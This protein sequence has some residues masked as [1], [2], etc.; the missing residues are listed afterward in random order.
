MPS[1]APDV[2]AAPSWQ[3]DIRAARLPLKALL[4]RL[5]LDAAMLPYGVIADPAFAMMV[6]PHTLSLIRPGDA[7][8]PL[9][10]QVLARAD[11]QVPGKRITSR[12]PLAEA[13]FTAGQGI[14][15]KYGSRALLLVSGACAI[16]CR[17]C[18]RRHYDYGASIIP[19]SGLDAALA[20][21]AADPAITEV[22]LSGGDPL[23]LSDTRLSAVLAALAAM[24]Q[25]RIIRIHT[26]TLTVVP[27][28]VTPALLA[29]L[30]GLGKPVVIVTHT[31]HA[32]ELDAVVQ[33]A[34][35]SVR[36]AGVQ[37]LNQAVLLAGINDDTGVL[38]AHGRRLLECG[39]LPYY[40]HMP[41]PVEGASHFDVPLARAREIESELRA[42]L[43]G[44]LVPRFVAEIPGA[45]S[46][47]PLWAL[48]DT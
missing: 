46:K 42:D 16:H 24:R 48:P 18:F 38:A 3:N 5:G 20:T 39:V 15:R 7:R 41:D 22:I 9:L 4:D 47:V 27:A 32:R 23:T 43:P 21:L 31:N 17:Y 44:Y 11:E 29:M 35:L 26:R 19:Q 34:L 36:G 30:A 37:L 2:D 33:A 25:V 13:G 28:R 45:P 8:D 1:A 6:P 12:D 14:L 40:L 10:L